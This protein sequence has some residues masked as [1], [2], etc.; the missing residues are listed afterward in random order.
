MSSNTNEIHLNILRKVESVED[1]KTLADE[2]GF[3]VGKINYILKHLIEK[4]L[5]KTE[6]FLK[7]ENKKGYRYLLTP[8]GVEAKIELTRAYIQIK[9]REY[10]ELVQEVESMEKG[11]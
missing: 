3:S 1:Q 4:G 10:E 6:R 5:I 9:K 11:K 2:L 7:S 8:S